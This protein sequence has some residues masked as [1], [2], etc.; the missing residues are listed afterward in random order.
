MSGNNS[1]Q[2]CSAAAIAPEP[3]DYDGHGFSL[4]NGDLPDGG[5]DTFQLELPGVSAGRKSFVEWQCPTKILTDYLSA[6]GIGRSGEIARRLLDEFGSLSDVIAA[7]SWRLRRVAG[8][9]VANSIL[10]SRDL[11]KAKLVEEVREAPIV[12]RSRELIDLLQLEI[13]FLRYERLLALYVDARCRLIRI[14]CLEEGHNSTAANHRK[15]IERGLEAGAYGLVLVHNHPSGLPN[16]STD[17]L[18]ATS[19]LRQLG[20][21]LDLHL[22]DHLIIARGQVGSIEDYWREAQLRQRERI[23]IEITDSVDGDPDLE[24]NGDEFEDSDGI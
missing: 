15:I 17:D 23:A 3:E 4:S 2:G 1:P 20:A 9:R 21:E 14:E 8:K 22:L 16:P 11:L 6:I 19:K 12:P 7:S 13:G 10:A 5:W 24:P 18:R